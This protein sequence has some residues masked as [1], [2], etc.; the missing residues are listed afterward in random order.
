MLCQ[1]CEQSNWN[2]SSISN[3]FGNKGHHE[4]AF[5]W[6]LQITSAQETKNLLVTTEAA[7]MKKVLR[8]KSAISINTAL[9]PEMIEVAY[10]SQ[11]SNTK[12]F[13]ANITDIAN[14]ELIKSLS[15]G[16]ILTENDLKAKKLVHIGKN[17]EAVIK[18]NGIELSLPAQALQSG[19]L[20]QIIQIKNLKNNKQFSA[21]I[22]GLNK[23]QITL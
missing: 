20:G 4:S 23:V 8:A 13:E 15:A 19:G 9:T 18:N 17:I 5:I 12:V 3:N 1:N 22:I 14:F 21:E 16:D 11:D 6:Q 7:N 2:N 10:L